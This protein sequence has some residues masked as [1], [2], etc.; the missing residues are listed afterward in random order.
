MDNTL[1]LFLP[2]YNNKK[3]TWRQAY[4]TGSKLYFLDYSVPGRN[5]GFYKNCLVIS[6]NETYAFVTGVY[7][8]PEELTIDDIH[9]ALSRINCS[10]ATYYTGELKISNEV[11]AIV[12]MIDTDTQHFVIFTHGGQIYAVDYTQDFEKEYKT[13][14]TML[15]D[16][17][18]N[19]SEVVRYNT[20]DVLKLHSTA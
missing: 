12:G 2:K 7:V 1:M 15:P 20:T 9:K 8:E 14:Y 3:H 18:Q 13:T 11:K 16:M 5:Y 4:S 17:L 6:D 10:A 19:K